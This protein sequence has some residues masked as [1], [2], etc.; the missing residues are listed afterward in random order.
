MLRVMLA[1]LAAAVTAGEEQLARHRNLGK[2]FF[3]NPTTH[4]LAVEEFRK[5]LRLAPGSAR[6][7]LNLGL[8]LLANGQT[9]EGIAEIESAQRQ[10]PSI[11]HTWFNLGIQ[12]KR[13]GEHDRAFR[14]FEGFVRRAPSEPAGHYNLGALHKL[15][16]R[17][18]EAIKAFEKASQLDPTLAAPHFQLYNLYRQANRREDAARRLEAFR[19]AKD[20]QANAAVP[21]DMEW[22]FYSEIL[23]AV[24]PRAADAPPARP[25]VFASRRLAA[26]GGAGDGS[27]HVL[28]A[29]GDGR[30]DLLARIGGQLTLFAGG[31]IRSK[32]SD[33]VRFAA[34]GD[35]NNDGL[36]DLCVL[37]G[38]GASL[39]L[40][41]K[42]RFAPR[43]LP[44]PPGAYTAAV[45][46]DY[47]RDYDLDL[48]LFGPRNVLLRNQGPAGFADRSADFPFV[49]GK[50]RSAMPFRLIADTKAWD[51]A[52]TY[53][54]RPAVLY[55]DRLGGRFEAIPLT[56]IPPGA[57]L[58]SAIDFDHNG[59]LDL[60]YQVSGKTRVLVN[61]NNG[62]FRPGPEA[63]GAA[64]PADFDNRG[65]LG[66]HSRS[67]AIALAAADFNL[68]GRGDL[69]V[70]AGDGALDLLTN[71]TSTPHAWMRVTLAGVKNLKLAA[72]AE[73]EI[74]AGSSYQKRV[75][76][77]FPVLFG[78]RDHRS[79]DAVRITWPNGLI[80]NETNQAAGR[81]ILYK[82][83]QRLSGSCPQVWSW[84][85]REFEYVTDVLGVAPLGALP[86]DSLEHI[87]IPRL[88]ARDGFFELRLTE[89]LAEVA[90]ID[91]VRLLAVDHPA[92]TEIHLNERF[93][94]A[95]YPPLEIF[96]VER[97]R[98]PATS[99]LVVA[100]GWIDWPDASQFLAREQSGTPYRMPSLQVPD[101]KG[102]W[103]TAAAAFGLPAGKPKSFAVALHERIGTFRIDTDLPVVW[104][105]LELAERSPARP[106]VRELT[107]SSAR[108]GYRGFS[109]VRID[110]Q[111]KAPEMFFYPAPLAA[112]MWNPTPGLYTRYGD[113]SEL[114]QSSDDRFVIMGSGDELS[115][116]FIAAALPPAGRGQTRSFV[117]AVDGWAK[118]QDPNTAHS[119]SVEPLPFHGMSAY[120]YPAGEKFP[121]GEVHREWRRR[122]NTRPALRFL[123]P[124][125]D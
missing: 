31:G 96:V 61:L 107:P 75:Y 4:A 68:D 9:K 56:A 57:I 48:I 116:R 5:A 39:L 50:G 65:V 47:D 44:A 87:R 110:P 58:T 103:R 15:A 25:P 46:L 37:T 35:F 63:E 123:R 28:D 8:A 78:L 83:A 114:T 80:Q 92:S 69:A 72:G 76:E 79:A 53:E 18:A 97:G 3:E 40:N 33:G 51:L 94:P 42:G 70:L 64:A 23:D 7:R 60:V 62:S 20:L 104:Q 118:D 84:N 108:L 111:R 91:Q 12:Y 2:A 32:I 82:E 1:A 88:A 11:P 71:R 21:E 52:V 95:P 77:G 85:G 16:G 106:V 43:P 59:S 117:L 100:A 109:R 98:R 66:L 54:D 102:G 93:Q 14:Q 89:E 27:L 67:G 122:Y 125:S 38:T 115:L 119:Q 26:P 41:T 29:E 81:G 124:L 101:G 45:W 90:Y 30:P 19:R 10:D 24:D 73:I 22:S 121:D 13:A 55:R 120:P 74:K 99:D 36:A 86:V 113:V 105:R 34:P 112:S 49:S 6:E 17:T